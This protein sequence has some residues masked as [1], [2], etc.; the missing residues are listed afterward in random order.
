[1][2]NDIMERVVVPDGVIF[3]TGAVGGISGWWAKPDGAP[4]GAAILHIHGGW[5]HWG[6]AR[7]FRNFAG[8]IARNAGADVFVPDCSRPSV[9]FPLRLRTWKR[10]ADWFSKGSPGSRLRSSSSQI[11]SAQASIGGVA[12]VGAVVFSPDC[13]DR[14]HPDRSGRARRPVIC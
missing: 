2:F 11:A 13:L 9:H 12:P 5:F 3:E 1:M 8:H 4:K 14:F 6:T 10:I 7:A